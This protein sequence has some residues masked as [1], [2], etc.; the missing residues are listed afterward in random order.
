MI[1]VI[2]TIIIMILCCVSSGVFIYLMTKDNTLYIEKA[3]LVGN[4]ISK[5]D[6]V[7]TIQ[8]C[9]K[10]C[11][12][13]GQCQSFSY[14]ANSK[15]CFLKGSKKVTGTEKALTAYKLKN[16]N[17]T[18]Y[19]GYSIDDVG[20]ANLPNM[21][22]N[23]VTQQECQTKCKDNADCKL[24]RYTYGPDT[25]SCALKLYRTNE[26]YTHGNIERNNLKNISV[27]PISVNPAK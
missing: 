26:L 4:D 7:Q 5:Q 15:Q 18:V 2:V 10:L 6:N 23:N 11:M 19:D 27:D 22:I 25:K 8:D 12:D 20:T 14:N 3:H 9:K 17:F 16:N 24:Y 1:L 13:E 21:P